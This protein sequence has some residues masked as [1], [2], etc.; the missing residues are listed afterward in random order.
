MDIEEQIERR[1]PCLCAS[2]VFVVTTMLVTW[3]KPVF[4]DSFDKI[5]DLTVNF[6]SVLIGFVGVLIG[7]LFSIR[8]YDLVK[9]LFEHKRQTILKR[10]FTSVILAGLLVLVLSAFLYL[11][12]EI[13][14]LSGK[15]T[16]VE[17]LFILWCAQ[18]GYMLGSGGRVVMIMLNIVFKAE[19]ENASKKHDSD[20]PEE[21]AE[22]L[23]EQLRQ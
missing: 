18:V 4:N 21:E 2:F 16:I 1:I 10:Y 8:D 7:L 22:Q 13:L 20:M 5:V 15:R 11:R 14:C 6:T 9:K 23:R 19:K 12:D 17:G 3:I